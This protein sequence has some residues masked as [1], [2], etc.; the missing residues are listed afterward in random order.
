MKTR[1]RLGAWFAPQLLGLHAFALVAIVVC[2]FMGLW[3]LGVY[4]ERQS[5]E[6]ADQQD[7]PRVELTEIWGPNDP[8]TKRQDMRPVS[9]TGEFLPADQQFWAID[10]EVEGELGVWLVAPVVVEDAIL[11][12]VRGWQ[13]NISDLPDVPLGQVSFD[14]GLLP[15]EDSDTGWNADDRT[16][17]SVRVPAMINV[18]DA[19]LWS[20]FAL[21]QDPSIAAGLELVPMPEKSASWTAGGRNLGYGL[22]WWAF[23]VFIAFMWWR[24]ATDMVRSDDEIA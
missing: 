10:K 24:M 20:G 14:A 5:E 2:V 4:D 16:I 9:V 18:Y 17:G 12:V 23:V 6:R 13:P 15:S 19:N 8:F 3:Q 7:V 1:T 21:A 22:Q 11:L